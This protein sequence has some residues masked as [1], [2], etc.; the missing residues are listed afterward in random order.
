[1]E[2]KEYVHNLKMR[3]HQY[4]HT[5]WSQTY[6]A[7]LYQEMTKCAD[8]YNVS[9]E[10]IYA[11]IIN[12]RWSTGLLPYEFNII[13]KRRFSTIVQQIKNYLRDFTLSGAV[14]QDGIET[15]PNSRVLAKP[16]WRKGRTASIVVLSFNRVD[17]LKTTLK[18]LHQSIAADAYELIVVDNASTDGSVAYLKKLVEQGLIAKLILRSKNHGI[19][20]GFNIGFAYANPDTDYL[21]KLDSDITIMTP[22]WF[23][24][25]VNTF[26]E[27]PD[28]GMLALNQANHSVLNVLPEEDRKG[29]ALINWTHWKAGGA[30]MTIPRA[31]FDQLGYFNESFDFT[32]MPDDVDYYWRLCM[33]G[34]DAYYMRDYLALHRTDLDISKY[35]KYCLGKMAQFLNPSL[36]ARKRL[37]REYLCDKRSR[38]VRYE[39]YNNCIFPRGTAVLEVP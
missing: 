35:S 34:L 30:C 33:L 18:S 23:D 38:V 25:F 36:K 12:C 1:M 2:Y 3:C 15:A 39:H 29:P 24:E 9:K 7:W 17:Y 37:A 31:V 6:G 32:Y 20:P 10:E 4:Y 16:G 8:L 26:E 11:E 28:I 19:S 5:P 27:Y 22:G 21:V 13:S 14:H